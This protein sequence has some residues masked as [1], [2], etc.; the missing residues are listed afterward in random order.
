[1]S[2]KYI[3]HNVTYEV[4]YALHGFRSQ[5]SGNLQE[6]EIVEIIG[7][8]EHVALATAIGLA[9]DFLGREIGFEESGS[10]HITDN[11]HASLG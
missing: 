4:T 9:H 11:S 2:G 6:L 3:F 5:L 7:E 8:V 1:M 10:H